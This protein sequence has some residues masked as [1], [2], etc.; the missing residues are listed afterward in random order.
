MENPGEGD[1]YFVDV[2]RFVMDFD[3]KDVHPQGEETCSNWRVHRT[4]RT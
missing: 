2:Y 3:E 4:G 1:N